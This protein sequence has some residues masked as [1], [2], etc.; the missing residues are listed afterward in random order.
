MIYTDDMPKLVKFYKQFE[1]NIKEEKNLKTKLQLE[2]KK[3][4]R[5][6]SK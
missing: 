2:K 6:P 1:V 3:R 5:D 4:P